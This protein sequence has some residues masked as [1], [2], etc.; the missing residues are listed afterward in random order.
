MQC[1]GCAGQKIYVR[2]NQNTGYNKITK[3]TV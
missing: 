3:K 1:G 2:E